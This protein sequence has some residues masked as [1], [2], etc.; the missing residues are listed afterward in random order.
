A[1]RVPRHA[2]RAV[3]EPLGLDAAGQRDAPG[4]QQQDSAPQRRDSHWPI[5]YLL[6]AR[7]RS[8]ASSAADCAP[9]RSPRAVSAAVTYPP[10]APLFS[11]A[12]KTVIVSP[13]LI[14]LLR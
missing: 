1:V 11:G 2:L 4:N 7:W 13:Y 12:T 6:S 9:N 10:S 8:R 5:P 14:M 3:V